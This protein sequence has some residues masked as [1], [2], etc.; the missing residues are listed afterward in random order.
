MTNH[1]TMLYALEAAKNAGATQAQA[2]GV[3]GTVLEAE[4][5]IGKVSMLRTIKDQS[6]INLKVEK[7]GKMGSVTIGTKEPADIDTGA[8]TAVAASEGASEDLTPF[9]NSTA[10]EKE[11]S[12]NAVE[13]D[14]AKLI[15]RLQELLT[16]ISKNFPKV[17][18]EAIVIQHTLEE[19]FYYNSHGVRLMSTTGDYELSAMF[20]GVNEDKGGSF[21]TFDCKFNDLNTRF[22]DLGMFRTMLE[23]A[24]N[25]TDPVKQEEKV[26][27][28]VL[29]SPPCLSDFMG[30]L[31][32]S[33]VGPMSILGG[34]SMWQDALDTQ[35]A[36]PRFSLF[37]APLD[38]RMAD[39]EFFTPDGFVCEDQA[40]I[41]NGVLKSLA[42]DYF[43]ANKTNLPMRKNSCQ[44]LLIPPG[45]TALDDIIASIEEGI[46]INRYSGGQPGA[47]GDISGIAKNSFYIKNGKIAGAAKETMITGNFAEMLKNIRAISKEVFTDGHTVLPYI[48]FDNMTIK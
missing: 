20:S 29:V 17:I 15:S 5:L 25:S 19:S 2:I 45:E 10:I 8:E 21:S 41:E 42:I 24:E 18:V 7:D 34:N 22:I 23:H 6:T 40:I 27:G 46:L 48:A 33:F 12:H 28:T 26:V 14:G 32:N 36:D 31:V 4:A 13:P 47:S 43:T 39:K 38:S 3:F 16:D 44:N 11:F 35:V 30:G 9:M 1:E 37:S